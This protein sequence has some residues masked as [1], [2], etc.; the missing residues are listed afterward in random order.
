[1]WIELRAQRRQARVGELR[2]QLRRLRLQA[3]VPATD[4]AA[5][6]SGDAAAAEP[7]ATDSASATDAAQTGD[8]EV[9]AAPELLE[10]EREDGG[11]AA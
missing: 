2:L 7:A 9:E 5:E 8:A 6:S 1:M 11:P 4:A 10:L 3:P